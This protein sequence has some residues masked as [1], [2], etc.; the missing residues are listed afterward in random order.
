ME[1]NINLVILGIEVIRKSQAKDFV[2]FRFEYI[3]AFVLKSISAKLL[4]LSLTT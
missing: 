4:C 1:L 3:F 2:M